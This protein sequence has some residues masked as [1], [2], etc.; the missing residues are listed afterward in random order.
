MIVVV[1]GALA[2]ASGVLVLLP[3]AACTAAPSA[4][5]PT[6]TS[7]P[8][9]PAPHQAGLAG[10]RRHAGSAGGSITLAFAGDVNF[11]GPNGAA[12]GRPGHRVRPG[13][14]GAPVG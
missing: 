5:P 2:A 9:T 10:T 4:H 8:G 13:N 14:G 1:R 12:A 3:L 11:A 7:R 6:A